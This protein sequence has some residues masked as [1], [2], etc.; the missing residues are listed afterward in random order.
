MVSMAATM[1]C[2]TGVRGM[3]APLPS[4]HR[5]L[6]AVSRAISHLARQRPSGIQQRGRRAMCTT[7]AGA[8]P[9]T[10]SKKSGYMYHEHLF[11]HC[12]GP[13]GNFKEH[14]QPMKYPENAETKRRL[15][16]LVNASGLLDE[17]K[18]IKPRQ[19]TVEEIT[20]YVQWNVLHT[21]KRSTSKRAE[22][23]AEQQSLKCLLSNC[24]V[25]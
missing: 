20:R 23:A 3:E 16:N 17:L 1:P 25:C 6:D 14:V 21:R 19:A 7:V 11:W 15:H 24:S 12:A 2:R 10:Q 22:C 5:A 18:V 4:M 13:W 8:L 9:E